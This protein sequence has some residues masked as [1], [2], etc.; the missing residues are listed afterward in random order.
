MRKFDSMWRDP[1]LTE[2]HRAH[3]YEAPAAGMTLPMVEYD[4][5]EPVAVLNYIRRDVAL[6]NGLDVNRTYLAL[7]G[8]RRPDGSDLPFLSVRYDPRNWATMLFP[9]NFSAIELLDGTGWT[10]ATEAQFAMQLYRLRGRRLPNLSCHGVDWNDQPWL[11]E[12]PAPGELEETSWPG[13]DMSARRRSYEPSAQVPF[14]LRVPCTDID[15]AVTGSDGPAAL[16]V[17]Y[18]REGARIHL[19]STNL[20]AMASL[21]A[22]S[23][24]HVWNVPAMVV[25]Y[26]FA[27]FARVF[28]V[29]CLN[30]SARQHLSYVL[31]HTTDD[32]G[33]W[34]L[35]EWN[36][37][38]EQQW[39][40]VLNCARDL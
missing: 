28:D 14:S 38:S 13:A 12:D 35:K 5:G 7:S 39:L 30:N 37:L 18:K 10:H 8:L 9:H 2:W 3:G 29:H 11:A 25:S 40:N 6:P 4:Y 32:L 34:P 15:L 24:N 31:G 17:D 33:W 20:R 26:D 27:G 16:V 36:R 23:S 19:G 1:A 22:R 21:Y